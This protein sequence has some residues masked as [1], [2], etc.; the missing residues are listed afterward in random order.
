MV[1]KYYESLIELEDRACDAL[2]LAYNP[3]EVLGECFSGNFYIPT[4]GDV[5]EAF[6]VALR[7][8]LGKQKGSPHWA[9]RVMW[10]T[11]LL[12]ELEERIRKGTFDS[13]NGNPDTQTLFGNYL[14]SDLILEHGVEELYR[15]QDGKREVV[16]KQFEEFWDEKEKARWT[17]IHHFMRD[18]TAEQYSKRKD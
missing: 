3:K 6:G 9:D 2:V 5:E 8:V 11:I 18:Y 13:I 1:T 14:L 15:F 7:E 16:L 4:Q 10:N 17:L 12:D